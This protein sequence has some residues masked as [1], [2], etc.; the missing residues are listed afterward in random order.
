M[1]FSRKDWSKKVDD[2]LSKYITAFK[3]PIG[4]FP[5][6]LVFGKSYHLLVEL[7]HCAY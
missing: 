7:E 3:T 5:Y 2:A 4:M 6:H 1:N